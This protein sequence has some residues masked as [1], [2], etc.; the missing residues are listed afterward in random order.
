[1]A[2]GLGNFLYDLEVRDGKA[3]FRFYD[4]EDAENTAEV[5][6]SKSEFPEGITQADSRQVADIAYAKCAKVLN[7]KRDAR[8][9]KESADQLAAKQEEDARQAGEAREFFEN[10]EELANTTPTGSPVSQ[11]ED[12][13]APAHNTDVQESVPDDSKK[14]ASSKD[15]K[16]K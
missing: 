2:Y 12:V 10:S 16:G 1:M 11:P 6:V 13:A 9:Q 14:D 8:F 7:D 3:L 15:K 5:E 4:P